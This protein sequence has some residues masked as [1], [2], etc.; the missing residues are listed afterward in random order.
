MKKDDRL[1]FTLRIPETLFSLVKDAAT[2]TGVATN[3][4]ILQILLQW[5]KENVHDKDRIS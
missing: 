4:M 3:A 1:R 2:Q 5:T